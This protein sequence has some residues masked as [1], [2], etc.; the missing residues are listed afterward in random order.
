MQKPFGVNLLTKLWI[1]ISL[2]R[3]LLEKIHEYVE[4]VKLLVVQV[5]GLM[6][7]EQCFYTFAFMKTKL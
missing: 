1:T 7:D 6:E 2:S 5:I 4:L 3:I